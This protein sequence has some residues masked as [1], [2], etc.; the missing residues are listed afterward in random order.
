MP[1]VRLLPV[2]GDSNG[3]LKRS[4]CPFESPHLSLVLGSHEAK[5]GGPRHGGETLTT[6]TNA[7]RRPPRG[8]STE[9]LN[10]FLR[11]V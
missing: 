3:R 2:R 10:P 6:D 11:S 1:E 5:A 8:T 9:N 4:F 7:R